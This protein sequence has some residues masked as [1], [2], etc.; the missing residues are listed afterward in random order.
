MLRYRRRYMRCAVPK[1]DR[2]PARGRDR[3]AA[4]G[5]GRSLSQPRHQGDQAEPPAWVLSA[6]GRRLPRHLLAR[7]D[8]ILV[9]EVD[10]KDDSTYDHLDRIAVHRSGEGVGVIE[11]AEAPPE[12]ARA[13]AG[14]APTRRSSERDRTNPLT[15]FSTPQLQAIG[16]STET[17]DAV[18]TFAETIE[19]GEALAD[20]GVSAETV[21]LVADMWHAPGRYLE[22]FDSG[23]TPTAADARIEEPELAGRLRSAESA[24]AVA[25]L[26]TGRLRTRAAGL[27]GGVDVLPAPLADPD[28]PPRAD[29]PVARARGTWHR[30]DRRGAAPGPPPRRSR[31]RG[32][33]PADDIRERTPRRV[34]DAA[35]P[36]RSRRSAAD[37]RA[38]R[39]QPRLRDHHRRKTASRRS[40]PTTSAAR[41]SRRSA[42]RSRAF[43]TRSVARPSSAPSSRR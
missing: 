16:L 7:G 42:P 30:Q 34:D 40:S 23:R 2:D 17:I 21:E 41:R 31:P 38:H 36:V 14:R 28:R 12:P 20:L 26:R 9:L 43:G 3:P 33:G 27:D 18:R 13:V 29:R 10:R 1:G 6:A 4:R 5:D 35:R 8:E 39:R 25:Q 11:V 19:P 32:L 24:D 37:H 15:V 22:I